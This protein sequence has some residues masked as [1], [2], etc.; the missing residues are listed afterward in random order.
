MVHI[1]PAYL[2]PVLIRVA[3]KIKM[4]LL[5][6]LTKKEHNVKHQSHSYHLVIM[7]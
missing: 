1:A 7:Q 4:K 2:I 5:S 3:A 6:S